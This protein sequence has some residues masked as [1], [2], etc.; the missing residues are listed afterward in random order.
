MPMCK[1][2]HL[3]GTV[4]AVRTAAKPINPLECFT[5]TLRQRL[6]RWVRKT[7]S[8]SKFDQFHELALKLLFQR[9][10]Q[11]RAITQNGATT[12][13]MPYTATIDTPCFLG[14]IR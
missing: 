11:E 2:F 9:Y 10:N 5:N 12:P 1:P 3:N 7:L 13:F 8:F 4:R 14:L 6:A